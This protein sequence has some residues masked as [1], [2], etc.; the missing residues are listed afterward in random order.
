MCGVIGICGE[1]EVVNELIAGLSALQH[2]GQDA[3]G[4]ITCSKRFNIKKGNGLVHNVFKSKNVA[5]LQGKLGIG[6][7]RYPTVG[8]GDLVDAQPFFLNSPLGIAMAHNGNVTNFW[9]LK[10]E[11]FKNNFRHINSNCDAE[12][13]LNV[14]ADELSK[15][16]LA[17]FGPETVFKTVKGVYRRVKG[18]Y[19]TLALIPDRGLVAFRDPHGI[20]PL[21]F[22]KKG[23]SYMFAS[24]SVAL[25]ILGY[26]LIRDLKPGEAVYI[27]EREQF[28]KE[29]RRVYER[30]LVK[31]QHRPCIF[32][33]V[34]FARPDSVMDG[35]S[36]YESR[37]RL[38]YELAPEVKKQKLKPDVVVPVPDTARPAA[39]ALARRLDVPLSEGLIKNRYIGRTFIMPGQAAR[40]RS[41]RQKLNPIRS[42]IRDKKVLLVDD[43]IVRGTTSREIINLIRGAGAKEV[44][45]AV[46]APPLKFPCVYGIDMQTR[47]E[48]IARD[49]Q[50]DKI[51]R[52]INADALIYQTLDG[53]VKAVDPKHKF[54]TAC[55][56]GTYPTEVPERFFKEIERERLCVK[57]M[58]LGCES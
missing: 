20:K 32:E 58:H 3:A 1:Q 16:D 5:R 40:E 28:F 47:S 41:V 45:F 7:V 31:E 14:F 4:I 8:G 6:H 33:W 54:C 11:L 23:N 42:E 27:E 10:E 55:F 13:I 12:A 36:V 52:E 9:E 43:S 48:F 2:R 17:K 35:I 18:S 44:Y 50:P 22:G 21:V 46:S 30:Q 56:T 29:G 25:D 39:T 57:G 15:Q 34:Y 37:I 26:E 51:A 53:L 19:A 38:G 49:R 24:E